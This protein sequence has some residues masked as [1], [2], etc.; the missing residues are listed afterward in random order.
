VMGIFFATQQL[1][2]LAPRQFFGMAFWVGFVL[3]TA[4]TEAWLR[5]GGKEPSLNGGFG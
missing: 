1:T 4:I 5:K 2:H 3:N